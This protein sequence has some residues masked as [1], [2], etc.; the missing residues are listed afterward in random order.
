MSK[1]IQIS[2]S[3]EVHS[4]LQSLAESC[5]MSPS[6]CVTQLIRRHHNDLLQLFAIDCNPVQPTATTVQSSAT[7][8]QPIAALVAPMP[9]EVAE[10]CSNQD[11]P[12]DFAALIA[13][14]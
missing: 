1:R 14:S 13:S 12:I 2:L 3:D 11:S 4:L 8:E 5:E 10:S 9:Q 6:Q 7:S